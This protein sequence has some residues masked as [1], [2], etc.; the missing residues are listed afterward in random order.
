MTTGIW[1]VVRCLALA[2]EALLVNAQ[3]GVQ[4][5]LR[6]A[7]EAAAR[8]PGRAAVREITWWRT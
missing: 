1:G 8:N 5:T 6:A 4:Q 3:P 7:R 2:L